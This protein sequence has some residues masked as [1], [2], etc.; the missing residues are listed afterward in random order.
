MCGEQALVT[1]ITNRTNGSSLRVRGTAI[2]V[3]D[4]NIQHGSS[5]RVQGNS[6]GGDAR[7]HPA[8]GHPCVC[9][10]Q[11]SVAIRGRTIV[12]SSLRVRGTAA[13]VL[14]ENPRSRVIPA[15]AGNRLC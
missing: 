9:G 7:R 11:P 10:E 3:T 13:L 2:V 4:H 1:A 6:H 14:A 12:G 5:L 8:T 15:C